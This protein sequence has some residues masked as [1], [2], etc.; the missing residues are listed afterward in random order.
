MLY[1]RPSAFFSAKG[2]GCPSVGAGPPS[3]GAA[4]VEACGV[5]AP[6]A[7][8]LPEA[9]GCAGPPVPVF[10]EEGKFASGGAVTAGAPRIGFVANPEESVGLEEG[11]ASA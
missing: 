4:E 11:K 5:A 8:A 10:L 3:D 6:E 2:P 7:A 1:G 9:V